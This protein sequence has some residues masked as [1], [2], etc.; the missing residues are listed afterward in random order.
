VQVAVSVN[1]NG[2]LI[3][4][5]KGYLGCTCYVQALALSAAVGLQ[6]DPRDVVLLA[7]GVGYGT[8]VNTYGVA[9]NGN[10]GN[11]LLVAGFNNACL[12]L[13]HFL[14]AAHHG[15]STVVDHT[16]NIAAMFANVK[17]VFTHNNVLLFI[18]SVLLDL[19][20]IGSAVFAKRTNEILGEFLSLVN[21][22]AN[23]ANVSF[24]AL[25]FGAGLNVLLVVCVGHC[26]FIRKN[27]CLGNGANEHP[28]RVDINVFFHLERNEGVDITR[29]ND[30]TVFG[31]VGGA[32]GK[33]VNGPA[34]NKA[35]CLEHL[36]RRLGS[37]T[38]DVHFARLLDDVVGIVLFVD[39]NRYAHGRVGKLGNGVNNETVILFAIVAG[40]NVK[41]VADAEK[42]FWIVIV[43]FFRLVC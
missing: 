8:D 13:G 33:L 25:G 35:K 36:K 14:S 16:N 9:L 39:G 30:K 26:F 19:F 1:G 28:V 37:E 7:H 2:G 17:L 34:A 21:I 43:H 22:A 27:L 11:V 6:I 20:K 18:D 32:I 15:N 41:T 29:K 24:F 4:E 31:A 5:C 38:V 23:L 10:Y 3:S 12:E 42:C 40:D